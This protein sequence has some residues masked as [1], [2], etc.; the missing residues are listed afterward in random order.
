MNQRT[1]QASSPYHPIKSW[2][3]WGLGCLFYFYEFLLQVSPNVMSH[4]LMHDFSITSRALG[5]LIGLYLYSYAAMQIPAGILMDYFGPRRLLTLA[6]IICAVSTLCFGMTHSVLMASLARLMIGLGSAFAAVGTMKLAASWFNSDRFALLTGMMVTIGTLGAIGGQAPLAVFVDAVGWR[7]S[8]MIMGAVGLLI[9][10]LIFIVTTDLPKTQTTAEATRE[11]PVIE[12][13]GLLVKNK[14]LWLVALYGGLVYMATPVLCGLWGVPFL[15]FKMHITKTVAANYI[16][17]ILIGWA[18][19]SPLWGIF[20]NRIGRRKPPMYLGA[21]GALI[22]S[23][24]FIFAPIES[25][26]AM[27]ALLFLF[28]IFSA[29]FLPAFAVAK[30]L[31]NKNYVATGLSFMNMVNMLGAAVAEPVI[32]YLLDQFWTGETI[33]HVRVYSLEAYHFALAFLPISMF[34]ALLI[35]PYIRETYCKESYA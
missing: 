15:M 16:S 1:A 5:V 35:L 2:I 4:E 22:T 31:C 14:Q 10:A 23:S 25:R 17:F 11:E 12:S 30:E 34:I 28:G 32:G 21:L 27:Q 18:I 13:L 6:T 7:H 3:V 20:S 33:N 24:C 8:M 29:A 9:A 19:A 26:F